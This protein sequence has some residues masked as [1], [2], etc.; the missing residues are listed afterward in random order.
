MLS[1]DRRWLEWPTTCSFFRLCFSHCAQHHHTLC[2]II[3]PLLQEYWHHLPHPASSDQPPSPW[4]RCA[5][6]HPWRHLHCLLCALIGRV[7]GSQWLDCQ[8]T[9]RK[10]FKLVETA[11]HPAH[12]LSTHL[13]SWIKPD[14]AE[15]CSSFPFCSLQSFR[16]RAKWWSAARRSPTFGRIWHG[17]QSS[18]C[19]ATNLKL[20]CS[21]IWNTFR[22]HIKL[23]KSA[24]E[25]SD[26]SQLAL[27]NPNA[28]CTDK[29][30]SWGWNLGSSLLTIQKSWHF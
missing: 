6:C 16:S 11:G 20:F 9:S 10:G 17:Q 8:M 21:N 30:S 27:A 26:I 22:N 19:P 24:L 2:S 1:D 7:A 18:A 4:S 13:I 3:W 29:S 12:P 14:I 28:T 25:S 23:F 15:T 5:P